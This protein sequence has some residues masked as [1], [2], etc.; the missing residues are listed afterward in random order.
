MK[1]S[2]FFIL[3]MVSALSLSQLKAQSVLYYNFLNSLNE[4]HNSAP[5]LTVL[6]NPGTY[7]TDT[8]SEIQNNHKIVYRYE[9]N[10]GVQ[11]NNAAAN[12]F[13]KETYTIELY[14]KFDELQS[15]KRV[16]DWKNR[17]TDWGAYVFNGQLNFYNIIYSNEAPV[18][19]GEYTYYV[20]TREGS[21]KDV[22][23]YTDAKNEIEF[24]DFSDDAV[25]DGDGVLNF[26]YDDLVVQ[27]EASSGTVALLKLYN[28][29]LDSNTVKTNWNKIGSTVFGIRDPVR[30]AEKLDLYPN[31]AST[32]VSMDLSMFRNG[33][34]AAI[35]IVNEYGQNVFSGKVTAGNPKTIISTAQF[36]KGVYFVM[37]ESGFRRASAKLLIR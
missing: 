14:F 23:I 20:I 30:S 9:A 12:N 29:S 8:L 5:A 19:P 2:A 3:T 28:S 11:F 13:I 16:V 17:K 32:Q 27:G 24:T 1:K 36:P 7:V 33:E 26:F 31:P 21:T 25:I 35:T 22:I 6:G 10:S 34:M 18:V 15:W 37:T 4:I